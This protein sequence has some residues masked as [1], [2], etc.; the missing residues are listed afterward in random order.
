MSSNALAKPLYRAPLEWVK[1]PLQARTHATLEKLLDTAEAMLAERSFDEISISELASAAG[2]S[3]GAFYRR[4]KD[5]DGLLHALQDRFMTEALETAEAALDPA[6][7]DGLGITEIVHETLAFLTE[8]LVERRG[9][10]RAVYVRSLTDQT[11]REASSRVTLHTMRRMTEL[12]LARREEISHPKPEVAVEVGLRQ[13]LSFISETCTIN[14]RELALTTVS[15]DE[16]SRETARAFLA[17]LGV[18]GA[19]EGA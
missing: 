1:P 16:V 7:W 19:L 12:V 18:R 2:S 15:N 17:Y 13:A 6:R 8:V 11:F 5:K 14:G 9:L 4:F 10:D 3:V